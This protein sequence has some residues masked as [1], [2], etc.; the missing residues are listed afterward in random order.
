MENR[1]IEKVEII[2]NNKNTEKKG[3]RLADDKQM[4]K[5]RKKEKQQKE[6]RN[7]KLDRKKILMIISIILAVIILIIGIIVGIYIYK[8]DGN[9]KFKESG[10]NKGVAK[11][12]K[13]LFKGNH[14]LIHELLHYV[15]V[16]YE[17]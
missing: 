6:K 1:N 8:A 15:H 14:D 9:M 2:E 4:K 3:N 10:E 11:V 5:K 7:Q 12:Y 16:D 13:E 17:K